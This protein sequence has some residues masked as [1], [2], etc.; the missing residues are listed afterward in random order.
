[1]K[2]DYENAVPQLSVAHAVAMLIG[3]VVG[4]GIFKTPIM[5]AANS[6]NEA[7]FIALWIA[8]G[9]LTLVGALCYAELGSAHPHS[10]GE[11]HYLHRAYGPA[12]SFLFAWGRISVMQSGAIAAVAFAYGD[13]AATLVP[14]GP[15]GAALH[16]VLAVVV[17]AILQLLGTGPSGR[18]QLVLTTMTLVLVLVIAVAAFMAGGQ[19]FAQ[20]SGIPQDAVSMSA[21][22]ALVFI[23]LTY[24]GWNEA[25]YL[26]GELRDARRNLVRVLIIGAGTVTVLYVLVNLALLSAFGLAGLAQQTVV[27]GP[28]NEVYGEAGSIIIGLAICIAA[29]STLNGTM[30]TGARSIYALAQDF[31]PFG[32][33]GHRSTRNAA[34]ANAI[35]TQ[36]AIA[37]ALIAYGATMRDGFTAMV[38]YTAPAFWSFLF[39]IGLSLFIFRWRTPDI[40]LPFRVPLYPVLPVIFCA[41]SLYLLYSSLVYTGAGALTGV[42]ILASGIPL[43]WLGGRKSSQTGAGESASEASGTRYVPGE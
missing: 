35:I 20:D 14:L 15:A 39:L 26:A 36:A 25:A 42:A 33:L 17:L 32:R 10:G 5:V 41:T 11:Y 4:I 28:V 24:G 43:Y 38:E 22:L 7:V 34:P 19:P 18:T 27:T 6:S 31:P 16:A 2:A 8:G 30:F 29:L 12:L 40:E 13:Y 37:L 1:M 21:G 23:L 3:I 9:A